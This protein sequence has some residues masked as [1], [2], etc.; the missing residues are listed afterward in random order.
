MRN[1]DWLALGA[2]GLGLLAA[3]SD[4]AG[5]GETKRDNFFYK[6][7]TRYSDRKRDFENCWQNSVFRAMS[8]WQSD[9]FVASPGDLSISSNM[10]L[11]SC[12][13]DQ[14]YVLVTIPSCPA[15]A[16]G[17]LTLVQAQTPLPAFSEVKCIF[18][19]GQIAI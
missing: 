9:T 13:E 16:R 2:F 4:L 6:E 18:D 17:V 15:E 12:M 14:E 7:G 19:S 11:T 1:R 8:I 5:N 10:R 3:C